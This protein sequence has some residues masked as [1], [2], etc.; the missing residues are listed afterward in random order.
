MIGY[1][2][3]VLIALV[4]VIMGFIVVGAAVKGWKDEKKLK[5]D[6]PIQPQPTDH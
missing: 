6:Q 4:T 1:T 2:L 5:S 3:L